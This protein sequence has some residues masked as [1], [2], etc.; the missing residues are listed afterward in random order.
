MVDPRTSRAPASSVPLPRAVWLLSWVSFLADVSSEMVYPLLP[1]FLVG[2]LGASKT[3]LG[4]VEGMAVLIVA[5]TTGFAGWRSDLLRKRVPWV[6]VGYGLPVL[7]K[8]II[9]VASAWPMVLCG[10]ILDRFGKGL[11]GAPRDA[12]IVDAAGVDQRGR[13]FG[14]H[15]AFDTAGALVGVLLSAFLLW[16]LTGTP[17]HDAAAQRAT[18]A[19]AWAYRAI[20]AAGAALGLASV[21]LTLLL[22]ESESARAG[23]PAAGEP[24]AR[25][26][27]RAPIGEGRLA[28]PRSYW[29][30]FAVLVLFSLANSSDA[31]LLLRASDLG[32]SPWMVVLLYA[33]FNLTYA[34]VS[35][36]AGAL[37]DRIG[38][39]RVIAVGWAV[40]VAV[41]AGFAL[42]PRSSAWALWPLMAAYGAYMGL[43]E[44]VGKALIADHAPTHRRGTAIG[45][46]H[47]AT[48]VTTLLASLIAGLA[49]DRAGAAWAFGIGAAFATAALLTLAIARRTVAAQSRA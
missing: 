12:L 15:R 34:A 42:V 21:L 8:A 3:E 32:F 33:L 11:R 48:G 35:Y 1:L 14:V 27:V 31:F 37:S 40:Y 39:W 19:P 49:W 29:S 24:L 17:E 41:Y 6:R 10:R 36:P 47:A 38:R 30:V 43:T 44:G 13:A 16:W 22:R 2:V 20:F 23:S 25:A 4:A 46:F 18:E 7:G 45:L 26:S 28:L 5:I 9:A